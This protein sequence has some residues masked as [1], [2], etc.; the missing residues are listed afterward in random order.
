MKKVIISGS[1]RNDG[2]TNT[3]TTELIKKTNWDLID[4]NDY[5]F[6]YYDY[7]QRTFYSIFIY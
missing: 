3:L 1:S 2:D 6:G 4:L 5:N 7:D